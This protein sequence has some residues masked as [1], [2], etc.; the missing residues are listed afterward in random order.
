PMACVDLAWRL[1]TGMSFGD[2][3]LDPWQGNPYSLTCTASD[4][5]VFTSMDQ[6]NAL[7]LVNALTGASL[8]A[9]GSVYEPDVAASPDGTSV[10]VGEYGSSGSALTRW[11]IAGNKLMQVDQSNEAGGEGR[12]PV[13]A[14]HGCV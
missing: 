5:L 11:T 3:W 9:E 2:A 10:Y 4:T 1:I 6:W 7:K 13:L 12:R 8:D 14:T